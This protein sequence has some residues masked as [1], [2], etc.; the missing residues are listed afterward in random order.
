MWQTRRR[1]RY[2]EQI[3]TSSVSDSATTNN[4]T[5]IFDCSHLGAARRT[6]QWCV[7]QGS[8]H[9]VCAMRL[10]LGRYSSKGGLWGRHERGMVGR[11]VERGFGIESRRRGSARHYGSA[12]EVGVFCFA[13]ATVVGWCLACWCTWTFGGRRGMPRPL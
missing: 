5:S 11:M 10:W 12:S 13:V 7:R 1:L 6:G 4:L 8:P 9:R 3:W 2:H